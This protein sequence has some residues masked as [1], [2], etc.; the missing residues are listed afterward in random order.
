MLVFEHNLGRQPPVEYNPFVNPS[1]SLK[2]KAAREEVEEEA[3]LI[4]LSEGW[5][6]A[7]A[8]QLERVPDLELLEEWVS[9]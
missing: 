8:A 6:R 4:R 9:A 1:F 5:S 2:E 3:E 7:R